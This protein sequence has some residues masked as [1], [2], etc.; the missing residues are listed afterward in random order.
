MVRHISDQVAVLYLGKIMELTD[1][2]ELYRTPLHPYTQALI[3]AAPIPNPTVDRTRERILLEGEIP[4][5]IHPPQGCR[6]C[7][8]C[9]YAD[10]RCCAEE[11]PLVDVGNEHLV[12]CH[13]VAGG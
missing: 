5:P 9:K 11:P 8:R 4:S 2:D 7:T 13:R 1:S 6:F 12:A 3:S 10:E